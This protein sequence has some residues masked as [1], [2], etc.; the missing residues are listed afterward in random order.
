MARALHRKPAVRLALLGLTA[1]ALGGCQHNRIAAID[2]TVPNDYRQRHPILVSPQGAYVANQCGQWPHDLGG[3]DIAMNYLNKPYWN[4]GCA[5]Q[6]NLAAMVAQPS[7]LL[8]P[9]G[10]T[11]IDATRRQ[12]VIARY[13]RGDSPGT[14]TVHV[15]MPPLTDVR[16]GVRGG[17]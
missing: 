9:R 4:Y 12:T 7:D 6:Q 10:Q 5:T 11:E 16:S 15:P 14:H 2:E 8:Q 3:S 13:R 17:G 1:L